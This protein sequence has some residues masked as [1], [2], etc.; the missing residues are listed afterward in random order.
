MVVDRG[1]S[2]VQRHHHQLRI[3]L[4]IIL[5]SII[6]FSFFNL[7]LPQRLPEDEVEA[8]KQIGTTVGM[9]GWK[10]DAATDPCTGGLKGVN[11]TCSFSNNTICHVIAVYVGLFYSHNFIFFRGK[12][13]KFAP[14]YILI[15]DVR[16]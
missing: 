15:F 14:I 5:L 2:S 10:F 16:R 12:K 8:L 6:Q 11:C 4:L 3:S 7:S 1:S 9:T 13:S